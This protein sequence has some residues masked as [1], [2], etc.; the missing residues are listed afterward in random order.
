MRED[1]LPNHRHL[2]HGFLPLAMA[3]VS[4]ARHYVRRG[5]VELIGVVEHV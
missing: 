5:P 1:P 3:D 4:R 2:P